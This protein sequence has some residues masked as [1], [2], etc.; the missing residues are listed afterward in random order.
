MPG[1]ARVR[2]GGGA[3]P[4]A[5]EAHREDAQ[6]GA[7]PGGT[8]GTAPGAA[9]G[10]AGSRPGGC[11]GIRAEQRR[12][13][14]RIGSR[15]GSRTGSRAG[16]C[17]EAP[18]AA[19]SEHVQPREE[20]LG[21]VVLDETASRSEGRRL[22][23]GSLSACRLPGVRGHSAAPPYEG[24]AGMAITAALEAGKEYPNPPFSRAEMQL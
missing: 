5:P 24:T 13:A 6:L 9:R 12:A 20:P 10:T 23:A 21:N 2:A 11:P 4:C 1:I 8:S 15:T 17:R 3:R 18:G 22:G 16:S 19:S 14:G 7:A